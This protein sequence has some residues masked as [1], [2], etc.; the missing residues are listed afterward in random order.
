MPTCNSQPV[1]D[2]LK[3]SEI[4]MIFLLIISYTKASNAG[5]FYLKVIYLV[6]CMN[7]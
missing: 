7:S 1:M 3:Y 2:W 6:L 5:K 4:Y